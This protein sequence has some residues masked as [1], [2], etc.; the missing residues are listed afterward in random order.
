MNSPCS[1]V[2]PMVEDFARDT[3]EMRLATGTIT[4]RFLYS[5]II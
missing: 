1:S 3:R 4:A 2:P 5:R